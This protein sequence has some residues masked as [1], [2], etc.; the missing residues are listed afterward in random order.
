VSDFFVKLMRYSNEKENT[1]TECLAEA[2]R[3]DPALCKRFLGELAAAERGDRRPA[4]IRAVGTQVPFPPGSCVDMVIRTAGMSI[5]VEHKLWS[6]EGRGQL[7]KYLQLPLDRIAFVTAYEAPGLDD[8]KDHPAYLRPR[9]GRL[10]FMWHDFQPGVEES[11]SASSG[12]LTRALLALF[13]HLGF[14]SPPDTI[15]DLWALDAQAQRGNRLQFARLWEKAEAGLRARGWRRL[16]R[17]RLAGLTYRADESASVER[18]WLDPTT[19]RGSLRIRL[20][21]RRG[22]SADQIASRVERASV[23]FREHLVITQEGASRASGR[24]V[25]V[26][27]LVSLPTLLGDLTG[28]EPIAQR[29]GDYTLAIIDAAA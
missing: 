6:P 22:L 29:L 26:D 13:R 1:F 19:I 27:V 10:H 25:V 12:T 24:A 8:V 3:S 4:G 18:V 2:L 9:S 14:E 7:A 20:S 23:S 15:P 28:A 17:A 16:R 11:A 21:P 5:G